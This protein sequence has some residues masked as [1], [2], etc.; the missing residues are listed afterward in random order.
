MCGVWCV[1]LGCGC[2]YLCGVF[3]CVVGV[4]VC[5]FLC[6]VCEVC[7]CLWVYVCVWCVCVCGCVYVVRVWFVCVCGVCVCM[8]VCVCFYVWTLVFNANAWIFFEVCLKTLCLE[9]SAVGVATSYG[10]GGP[11][12]E[13]RRGEIFHTRPDRPWSPPCLLYCRYRVTFPELKEP[14][15]GV[16]QPPPS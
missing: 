7:V 6:G 11:G 9:N 12:I 14:W 3:F 4:F 16:D 10:L 13:A 2:V 5:M 15:R 1:C 8:C